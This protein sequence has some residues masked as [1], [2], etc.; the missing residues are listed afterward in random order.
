MH[1]PRLTRSRR[2]SSI[3][4]LGQEELSAGSVEAACI[5]YWSVIVTAQL[6]IGTRWRR[7]SRDTRLVQTSEQQ[8]GRAE[9]DLDD[10]SKRSDTG[11]HLLRRD[12]RIDRA[13]G[14]K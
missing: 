3:P 1:R 13:E 10:G 9:H 14:C 7:A 2:G 5:L 12:D 6:R 11:R 8:L 4:E